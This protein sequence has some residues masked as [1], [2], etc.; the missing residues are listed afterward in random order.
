MP[1]GHEMMISA[2]RDSNIVQTNARLQNFKRGWPETQKRALFEI[3]QNRLQIK[4]VGVIFKWGN[5]DD[6]HCS[7]PSCCYRSFLSNS[8]LRLI[9]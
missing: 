2:N 9:C 4:D 6:V 3:F 5:A 7:G 8:F 1:S